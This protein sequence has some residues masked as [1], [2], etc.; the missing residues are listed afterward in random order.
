MNGIFI[1]FE[2][3]EGAGKSTQA[4]L[5]YEHLKKSGK[6]VLHLRE[7]G[8]T[9]IGEEIRNI[10]LDKDNINMLANTEAL[11]YAAS[12]AQIIGEIIKPHLEEGYIIVCDRF[13]DSSYAYQGYGRGLGLETVREIN[14]YAINN[15]MPN[16]TFYI[17]LDPE[18]GL[19]RNQQEDKD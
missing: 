9:V 5:L 13:I 8:G 7:P 18:I 15:I 6:K 1:S 3:C 10:I 4:T 12:R 17:K 19:Y 14:S 16:I 2:G 11:L